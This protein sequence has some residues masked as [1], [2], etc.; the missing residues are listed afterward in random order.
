V[1]R[2]E[3]T[4]PDELTVWDLVLRARQRIWTNSEDGVREAVNLLEQARDLEPDSAMVHT[5]LAYCW[6]TAAFN[7]WTLDGRVA[8][9][10]LA[11]TSAEAYR[12]DPTDPPAL[13]AY[14]QTLAY[15]GRHD[16]AADI[17]RRALAIAPDDG[18]VLLM[19]GTVGLFRGE[20]L[21]AVEWL[22]AAWRL[23]GHE[24]WKFHIATNLAFAQ[25][26]AG[27][28]E[29]AWAWAQKGLDLGEYL[30]LRAIGAAAL[31]Q[32]GRSEEA[33]RQIGY[34]I[35]SLPDAT[36]LSFLRNISWKDPADVEHY[37]EGLIAAGLTE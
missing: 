1:R 15:L 9:E 2:R 29:A 33:R 14:G 27:N 7:R 35:S 11:R 34:V 17:A 13:T 8:F 18:L 6:V 30:Q 16:E 3:G 21:K 37:R 12:L 31:G 36:T 23:A 32:L 20:S 26:L 10:E 24:S 28:Y 5:H 4:S 22:T 25:Y 19:A